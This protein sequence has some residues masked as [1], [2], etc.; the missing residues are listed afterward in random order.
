VTKLK[1]VIH[2]RIES[3][4][5]GS[6][7]RTLSKEEEMMIRGQTRKSAE[8]SKDGKALEMQPRSAAATGSI[9]TSTEESLEKIVRLL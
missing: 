7:Q 5:Q 9:V 2:T 6:I 8:R 4:A 1:Q 3:A